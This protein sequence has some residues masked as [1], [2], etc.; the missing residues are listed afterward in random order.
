MATYEQVKD[1]PNHPDVYLID[2][3]RKEELQ[4]TG[5]I[6][7]S[8]N[9]PLDEL[10]KALNLD[11]A[12]FKNKYGRTKPEKQSRIIF[13]CRSGNRVLEAEKIAKSQG[14]SNVVIYKGSWNEWAQK[15]GL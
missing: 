3:R 7:A 9:I 5:F 10:D 11:G 12:A 15:E 4:Q 8:I 2:V 13:S 6:P 14:Y 1:V